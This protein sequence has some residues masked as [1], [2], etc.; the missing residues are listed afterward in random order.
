MTQRRPIEKQ[1]K[2]S[3]G[4]LEWMIN[5]YKNANLKDKVY[6]H[7]I[8]MGII[9]AIVCSIFS[10]IQMYTHVN[11]NFTFFAQSISVGCCWLMYLAYFLITW[12][13]LKYDQELGAW[14]K[15][16]LEGVGAF[17]FIWL[18]IWTIVN[19]LAWV[20]FYGVPPILR[21]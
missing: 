18:F 12:K 4:A 6:T 5:K 17:I 10:I 21:T 14:H 11:F 13:V 15:I 16:L 1:V 9:S 3:E 8:I 20:S 2:K 19:T 7:K